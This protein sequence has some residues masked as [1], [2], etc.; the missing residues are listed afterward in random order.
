MDP[1][2]EIYAVVAVG[3]IIA[4]TLIT[5]ARSKNDKDN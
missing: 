5:I 3:A 1:V 4:L 2:T